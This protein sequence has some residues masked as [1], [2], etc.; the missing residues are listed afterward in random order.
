MSASQRQTRQVKH[1]EGRT[2]NEQWEMGNGKGKKGKSKSESTKL[3]Q[4]ES[5]YSKWN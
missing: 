5:H 2:K 1:E 4:K 3:K